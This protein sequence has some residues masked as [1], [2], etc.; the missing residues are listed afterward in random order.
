M[1]ARFQ[2]AGWLTFLVCSLFFLGAGITSGNVW[3]IGG[4][5]TFLIGVVLFLLPFIQKGG[6]ES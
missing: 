4:G 1:E 2:L 5:V 3:T 6:G